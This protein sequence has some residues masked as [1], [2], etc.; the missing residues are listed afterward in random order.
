MSNEIIEHKEFSTA[1]ELRDFLNSYSDTELDS[2]HFPDT[3]FLI[4]DVVQT[5]LS[6]GSTVKDMR[7]IPE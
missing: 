1:R 7:F 5:T 4:V 2:I 6:D 3:D